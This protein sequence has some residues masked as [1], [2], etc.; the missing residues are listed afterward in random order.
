[1]NLSLDKVRIS[2]RH[3]SAMSYGR[4][5][6]TEQKLQT[7]VE[8]LLRRAQETDAAEDKQYGKGKRGD[9]LPEELARRESRLKKIRE[10]KAALE[11]EARE[12]AEQKKAAAE[13]KIAERHAQHERTGRKPGGRDP[14]VPDPE[15]A[16]PDEKAQRNFTDPESRIMP[17]GGRKGSSDHRRRRKVS[18]V[19]DKVNMS[20]RQWPRRSIR[21]SR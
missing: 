2:L 13:A 5:V 8:E 6:E 21:R 15:K 20:L 7:E 10:A 12:E 19:Q 9:E 17:D 18:L 4:M 1:M 3:W 11:A 16:V 14:Q